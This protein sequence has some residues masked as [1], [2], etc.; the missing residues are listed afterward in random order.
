MRLCDVCTQAH[1]LPEAV[2]LLPWTWPTEPWQRTHGDYA[3]LKSHQFFL[4][5]DSNSKWMEAFPR[6]STTADS[7]MEVL[8]ALFSRYGL[9]LE[10]FSYNGP[11]FAARKFQTFLKINF[12]KYTLRPPC[13][14]STNGL[15]DRHVQN[16]K[17]MYRAFP[18]KG[19]LQH[20]VANVLF[21]YRNTPHSTTDKA[22][23][24]L[25]LKWELSTHLSLVRPSLQRHVERKQ[26]ASKLYRDGIHSRGRIF[27]F[28]SAS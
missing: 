19:S 8:R 12:I 9:P 28:Y 10:L 4:V 18:D 2:T 24:Q 16:F 27:R 7:T 5:V 26:V 20:K 13:H 25:F 11:Q 22:P 21:R 14:P 1:H 6:R 3:E 23:A 15:A 17:R